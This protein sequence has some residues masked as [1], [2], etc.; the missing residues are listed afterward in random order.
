MHL[1]GGGVGFGQQCHW[2]EKINVPNK[3]ADVLSQMRH[4]TIERPWSREPNRLWLLRY[5]SYQVSDGLNQNGPVSYRRGPMDFTEAIDIFMDI[6]TVLICKTFLRLWEAIPPLLPGSP[7]P[8]VSPEQ[9]QPPQPQLLLE[10]LRGR[11]QSARSHVLLRDSDWHIPGVA[12]SILKL[13]PTKKHKVTHSKY[14]Q[15]D[16]N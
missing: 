7:P 13:F 2:A 14:N 8:L 5:N 1:R 11:C 10:G 15:T 6:I 3:K 16:L 9:Q 12:P 4:H